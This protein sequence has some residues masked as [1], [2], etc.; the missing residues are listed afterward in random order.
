M[1]ET[2][3]ARGSREWLSRKFPDHAQW[4]RIQRLLRLSGVVCVL[5]GA[6]WGAFYGAHGMDVLAIVLF[7]LILVGLGCLGIARKRDRIPLV[8]IAHVLL[9]MTIF[10][11]LAETPTAAAARSTHLFLLPIGVASFFL[12]RSERVYL[13]WLFPGMCIAALVVLAISP[14]SLG[15]QLELLTDDVRR[16]RHGLNTLTA[17]VLTCSVLAIFRED[18]SEQMDQYAAL[19]RGLAQRELR[20]FLQPQVG[21]DGRVLG[22]EMLLRWDRP[23]HGLQ[24]PDKFIPLAEETGLI[25]DIGLMVLE[26]A[27]V[28]LKNWST[29]PGV[30]AWMLSVNVSPLQLASDSFVDDV[31]A[32]LRRV[33][34]PP[35]RLRL[36]ITESA[37]ATDLSVLAAKMGALR[38]DG[39]SWSLDD[40]GTGF[41]SFSLLQAL[42]LDEL[43]IDQTFVRGMGDDPSQRE[44]VRKIIEIAEILGIATVAEGVETEQQREWLA[45]MGCRVFQGY[46]FGRPVSAEAFHQ[47]HVPQG[48]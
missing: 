9:V 40:F 46:L 6:I 8:L 48:Q 2:G 26:R 41:S 13:R 33:G 29:L 47:A 44:L 14:V 17:M 37:L 10:V 28:H 27:C 19:V 3:S 30:D 12:F 11:S 36:E 20:A 22:A 5:H 21:L 4:P 34:A 24:S 38:Q 43:K 25:H 16:L 31:R 45:G 18:L 32:T 42:P 15:P 35:N 39:I 7:S 23:G 1:L